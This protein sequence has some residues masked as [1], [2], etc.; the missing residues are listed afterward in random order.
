MEPANAPLKASDETVPITRPVIV[1][2]GRKTKKAIKN[3]KRGTGDT[4]LEVE[5]AIRQ[6]RM[7]LS[8]ADKNKPAIPIVLIYE[9]KRKRLSLPSLPFSPFNLLR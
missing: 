3:L 2:L 4:M 8:E 9:R 5:A 1:D 6:V 7:R